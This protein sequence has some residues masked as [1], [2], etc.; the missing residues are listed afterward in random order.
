MTG[1]LLQIGATKLA[2]SVVLAAAVWIVHRRVD[3]PAVS[4]PLWLMVLLTLVVPAVTSLPVLPAEPVAA[5][6][7]PGSGA[8]GIVLA[9]VAAERAPGPVFGAFLQPGLAILWLG[10]TVG[11]LGWTAVRA[12]RFRR[13]LKR[14]VRPAPSWLRRQA[15]AVGRDLGL[16]RIPELCT[17]NARVTPMVWWSGG[18]VRML[19]PSFLLRDPGGKELRAIL[20]HE[21]AHVRRRDHLVRWLEWLACSVF[22]WNPVA[23]WARHHL[24]TAEESCCDE[25]ALGMGRSCPKTYAKALLRVV[26][27]ASEPRGFRPPLPASAAGG[28]GQTKV[29]ERRIRMIVSTDNRSPAPRWLRTAS[30]LAMACA[31][32]FGLIYCDRPTAIEEETTMDPVEGAAL[33]TP[34]EVFAAVGEVLESLS[35]RAARIQ[36]LLRELME[37]GRL[38]EERG[39]ELSAFVSGAASG[40]LTRAVLDYAIA[41]AAYEAAADEFLSE[42]AETNRELRLGDHSSRTSTAE[43]NSPELTNALAEMRQLIGEIDRDPGATERFEEWSGRIREIKTRIRTALSPEFKSEW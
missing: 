32:P 26:A 8:V 13:T 12:I 30:R 23:W 19:I 16:S 37:S 10:G 21:L 6:V 39:R 43:V 27:N 3:R 31:L 22:W 25:L 5:L 34:D 14:A 40:G 7:A 18:R 4:Y 35:L 38:S 11:L 9:E 15:A 2:V 20:A 33:D 28:A 24:R 41:A 42:L 1:L 29:L 17:T 36:E